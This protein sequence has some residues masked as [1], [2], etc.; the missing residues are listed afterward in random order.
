[1]HQ[2]QT[3]EDYIH[4]RVARFDQNNSMDIWFTCG[5]GPALPWKLYEFE[6]IG[7]EPCWQL[8]YMQD[9]RT[10]QQLQY[11]KY[12]PPF[13]LIKLDTSDETA[14][15]DY[16]ETLLSEE[17]LW[18]FGWTCFEEETQIDDFQARLM[19]SICNLSTKSHDETV[20]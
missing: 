15:D 8:P 19:Q 17:H 18:E 3:I 9:P 1:M 7:D 16:M 12:S 14:F 4:D 5:Y 11:R 13:A 20:S 6:P 10:G 2:K